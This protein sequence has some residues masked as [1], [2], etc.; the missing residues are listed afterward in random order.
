FNKIGTA[1]N[2][3][4]A[5]EAARES[6][7][8]MKNENTLPLVPSIKNI[9]VAGPNA[10]SRSAL[11]GGWTLRWMTSDEKL[12]PKDML[13]VL[14]GLQKEFPKSNVTL[15]ANDSELKSKGPKADAIVM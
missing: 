1:E 8:L 4:K 5:L 10:N 15:A 13:T 6:I 7:V 2:R 12:Y 9:L 3:A 11:A 14:T